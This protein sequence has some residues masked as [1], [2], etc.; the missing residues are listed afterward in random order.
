MEHGEVAF[1]A[2]HFV[3][4]VAVVHFVLVDLEQLGEV[5]LE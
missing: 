3:C 1:C 4:M 2:E 5:A